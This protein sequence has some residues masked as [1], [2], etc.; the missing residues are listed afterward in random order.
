LREIQ[1]AARQCVPLSLDRFFDADGVEARAALRDDR[2]PMKLRLLHVSPPVL[3]IDHFFTPDECASMKQLA[4][5]VPD[6]NPAGIGP[7]RVDSRTFAGAASTRTSTSWFCRYRDAPGLLAK[8][9][10]ALG[11]RLEAME[12]PQ[13]VRYRP[14]QEFS[15][16][17]DVVP[18]SQLSNGGQRLATLLYVIGL[19]CAVF[20]RETMRE[21]RL[22]DLTQ[23]LSRFAP[24]P[25]L[26]ASCAACT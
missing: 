10:R 3:S 6:D 25:L 5:A 13:I 22:P 23:I 11:L 12:E 26:C 4:A 24:A 18:A 21:R 15:F 17:Y 7:V 19:S 16:H 9:Q 20:L 8:A 2:P 14:G 1:D